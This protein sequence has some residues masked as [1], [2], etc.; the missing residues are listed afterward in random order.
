ME[1]KANLVELNTSNTLAKVQN[2][3][4][5]RSPKRFVTTCN[6]GRSNHKAKD[7][8]LSKKE[9]LDQV[10]MTKIKNVSMDM[11]KLDLW[12]IVFEVNSVD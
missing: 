10:Y 4:N 1:A 11:P 9:H 8:C 12:I 6:C 7:C 3:I 5:L 2:W